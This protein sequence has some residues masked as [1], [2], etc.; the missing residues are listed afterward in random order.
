MTSLTTKPD[1]SQLASEMAVDL[2]DSCF[3]PIETEVRA[4]ARGFIEELIRGELDDPRARPRY[5]RSNQPSRASPGIAQAVSPEIWARACTH[6][7]EQWSSGKCSARAG[8]A[9]T[10]QSTVSG[11][12]FTDGTQ[13]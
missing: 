13:A 6:K 12:S 7:S 2:F 10:R 1:S 9:M 8:I 4:R 3:D 11:S 5:Q